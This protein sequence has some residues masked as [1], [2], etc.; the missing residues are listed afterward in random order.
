M[1]SVRRLCRLGQ[2]RNNGPDRSRIA[3]VHHPTA[4]ET[5]P[6]LHCLQARSETEWSKPTVQDVHVCFSPATFH[7]LTDVSNSF[8]IESTGHPEAT[9]ALDHPVYLLRDHLC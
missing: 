9:L 1:E 2:F 4:A 5:L 7:P 3:R 8:K 6:G